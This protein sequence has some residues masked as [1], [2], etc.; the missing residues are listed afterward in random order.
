MIIAAVILCII[1]G[2]LMIEKS[3]VQRSVGNLQLRI[4]VN[5]TRG[6]SSVTEYIAAGLF[7]SRQEVMAKITGIIPKIIH[8]GTEIPIKRTGGARVQEQYDVIRFAARKKVKNLILECMSIDPE[9]QRM[10]SSVFKPHIYV[11]TNIKDDHREEMGENIEQQAEAICNA[12]PANCTVITNEIRFLDLIREHASGKGS[13]VIVPKMSY[14]EAAESLPFGVFPENIDLALTVCDV[15]GA[16]GLMA[17]EGIL[18][19]VQ[20]RESP[21]KTINYNTGKIFF[22]NAFAVNDV[23]STSIF[24]DHWLDK[25]GYQGKVNLMFNTRA[26]RPVRT[27]LFAGWIAKSLMA[28]ENIILTGDHAMRARFSL[29]KAGFEEGKLVVWR[30]GQIENLKESLLRV[31]GDGTIVVGVGNIG[32]EGFN[33]LNKLP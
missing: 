8:N 5:G 26:D 16:E 2:F 28:F 4:H 23:E 30:S 21:L 3:V 29:I 17:R 19:Y 20:N 7:G 14:Q 10:E 12:I 33:I 11:I 27:D 24:I 9:L 6:K 22:L 31:V 13:K 32:G 18:K 25:I 15:A 1:L